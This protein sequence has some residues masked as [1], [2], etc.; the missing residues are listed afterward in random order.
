MQGFFSGAQRCPSAPMSWAMSGLLGAQESRGVEGRFTAQLS[1]SEE[2]S[3]VSSVYLTG[4]HHRKDRKI[5]R[6]LIFFFLRGKAL[7]SKHIYFYY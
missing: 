3:T 1:V 6:L 4:V 2:A 5:F 7:N